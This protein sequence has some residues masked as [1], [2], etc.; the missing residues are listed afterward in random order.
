MSWQLAAFALL[1]AVIVAGAVWYERSRPSSRTVALVAALAALAVAGRLVLAPVPN[2]VATTDV[3]LLTGYALG[4]APGFA[5]GA[6]AAPVSNLW[7]GQG[8]WT[9]WQMA[10]WGLCGL[11]GALLAFATRRGIGRVGLASACAFAGLAYG[12][13]L[14]LSVMVSYGGEQSLDRYVALSARGIPFNL[15]HAAGNFAI[16]LAAGPALVR[17]ISRFRERSEFTW[18]PV[19]VAPMLLAALVATSAAAPAPAEAAGPAGARGYLERQQNADGGYGATPSASSNLDMTAWA[20]LGMEASGRNPLDLSSRGRTPVDFLRSHPASSTADLEKVILALEGAS[21]SSRSFAGRDL[22]AALRAKR[23]RNGSWGGFID[24]TAFGVFALR[25]AGVPASELGR[26]ASWLRTAQN[27]DGGW[28]YEPGSFSTPDSTGSALQALALVG[29]RSA[30]ADGIAY[31]RRAQG[32]DGGWGGNSQGTAWALQ[33]LIASGV[34]PS[35]VSSGG[36]DGLDYLAA[37]QAGD[38]H[39]RYSSS[40]DQ[41]PVW[42]TSQALMAVER[43]VFPVEPVPRTSEPGGLPPPAGADAASGPGPRDSGSGDARKRDG[44]SAGHDRAKGQRGDGRRRDVGAGG[45]E[46][47]GEARLARA[48]APLA[49]SAGSGEDGG[50]DITPYA[51]GGLGA[52]AAC[53]GGGFLWYRRRLP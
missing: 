46:R 9:P 24:L 2:V 30:R 31:L 8:P 32:G 39:Y 13:L 4:A 50:E 52:L 42:V 49:G 41:T 17:M 3:A 35:S 37:R 14:D 43:E 16:A 40:S 44:A 18:R 6:L 36:R 22:V 11:L 33:G 38:G 27:D 25:A 34:N 10:G 23:S 1:S 45:P 7:L 20:M 48:D 47:V 28:G 51:L 5:V 26:T 19:A 29:G 15:A 12:A 53:L 21:I